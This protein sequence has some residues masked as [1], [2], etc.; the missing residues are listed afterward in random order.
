MIE[1][2]LQWDHHI[3]QLI[4]QQW[5]YGILDKILPVLRNKYFWTPLYMF[6]LSFFVINYRMQG[7]AVIVMIGITIAISDQLS[8]SIIK[9]LVGRLRPCNDT[10]LNEQV[11]LLISCG[12]G[13][14]FTSSHATNHFALAGILSFLLNKRF[15]WV[16]PFTMIWAAVVSYAQVYVGVHFPLDIIS[17]G[18]LGLLIGTAAGGASRRLT[19][20]DP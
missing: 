3:F 8:S 1:Q 17:G 11:R 20:F 14:S 12:S 6:F 7:V 13:Y 5:H 2:L 15:R 19:K 4:N 16:L 10:D 9:P 18:L